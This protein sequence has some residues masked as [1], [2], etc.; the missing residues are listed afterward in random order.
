MGLNWDRGSGPELDPH[1]PPRFET[2]RKIEK[3][4]EIF[5][6]FS[7]NVHIRKFSSWISFDVVDTLSVL[8][9]DIKNIDKT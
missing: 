6:D 1:F 2:T 3:F 9:P 4:L 8:P 5:K 7:S